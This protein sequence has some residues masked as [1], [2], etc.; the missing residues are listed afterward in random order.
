LPARASWAEI[1][2]YRFR[3]GSRVGS[4]ASNARYLFGLGGDDRAG[5]ANAEQLLVSV[6]AMVGVDELPPTDLFVLFDAPFATT[7]QDLPDAFAEERELVGGDAELVAE[8]RR[9]VVDRGEDLGHS[10]GQGGRRSDIGQ[11]ERPLVEPGEDGP[12]GVDE[13]VGHRAV[14]A[15]RF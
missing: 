15:V 10:E 2:S 7:G 14:R 6:G 9:Q 13:V 1:R 8:D 11:L 12:G 5:A 3:R 4:D